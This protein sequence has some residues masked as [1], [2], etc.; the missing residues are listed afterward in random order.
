MSP[1]RQQTAHER[2]VP[3]Y[4]F[5]NEF[6][7]GAAYQRVQLVESYMQIPPR[8][9][10]TEYRIAVITGEGGILQGWPELAANS[11]MIIQVDCDPMPLRLSACFIEELKRLDSY[12][13]KYKLRDRVLTRFQQQ[14]P[15]LTPDQIEEIR[16]KFEEY[17]VHMR[18]CIFSTPERFEAFKRCQD[19]PLQQLCFSY[20]SRKAMDEFTQTLRD[21]GA[22]VNFFNASNVCEYPENFYPANPFQGEVEG[23]EPSQYMKKLPFSSDAVCA[24]SQLFGSDF[25]TKTCPAAEMGKYLHANAMNR[26]DRELKHLT[27]K[28]KKPVDLRTT[29]A[30][31]A[32]NRTL[33]LSTKVFM[34]VA[35]RPDL[36]C[37]EWMLR[38]AAAR[39]EP[40]AIE[41][42]K[43]HQHTIRA[44]ALDNQA[45]DSMGG[46]IPGTGLP[47]TIRILDKVLAESSTSPMPESGQ[48]LMA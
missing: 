34:F 37:S 28:Y 24:H 19:H 27:K 26:L 7:V 47:L 5:S 40:A 39:L 38:L 48:G 36:P 21:H 30:W 4:W 29:E 42:L 18:N 16:D 3:T 33:L 10:L 6:A 45:R 14:N 17:T 46:A 44:V 23:V 15:E 12:I 31:E 13:D 20:F 2:L 9:N 1:Y 43:K 22:V 41:E 32:S 25:F 11:D 8:K 35:E